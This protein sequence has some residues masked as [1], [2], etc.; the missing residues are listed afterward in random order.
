MLE[1]L[2]GTL[3]S[4]V[5]GQIMNQAQLPAGNL[6]QVFSI[7]GDVTKKEVTQQMLGG[8]LSNVMNLFSSQQN[9]QAADLIQS[10]IHAGVV[11]D[12]VSKLGL[13]KDVS[14]NI[15]SAVIPALVSM[16]TKK[17]S[18]TPDDDPSPLNEIF[19][20]VAGTGGLGGIAKGLLGRLLKR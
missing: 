4:E 3:K 16:I 17:N 13:S 7:I 14:G 1:K 19:G 5:G 12:L 2:L 15:A 10:N 11:G 8:G 9:N 6:D 20:S 18:E